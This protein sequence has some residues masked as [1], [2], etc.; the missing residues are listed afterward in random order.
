MLPREVYEGTAA[1]K[2]ALALVAG[3]EPAHELFMLIMRILLVAMRGI[4][5]G[6]PYG[7]IDGG[8]D[9]DFPIVFNA[10][11]YPKTL[12]IVQHL[13]KLGVLKLDAE[14]GTGRL[15]NLVVPDGAGREWVNKVMTEMEATEVVVTPEPVANTFAGNEQIRLMDS[16][17]IPT[18]SSFEF[19]L[20]GFKTTMTLTD[21]GIRID[22]PAGRAPA[23]NDAVVIFNL[24][25]LTSFASK[26]GYR[27]FSSPCPLSEIRQVVNL[28]TRMQGPPYTT[29]SLEELIPRIHDDF[30]SFWDTF[31]PGEETVAA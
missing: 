20:E 14:T 25:M 16:V 7:D 31:Q 29:A 30:K 15:Y 21:A 11:Y 19:W 3:T 9:V 12:A 27:G 10:P 17:G 2:M 18:D 1:G 28:V 13:E 4:R 22:L 24:W 23:E 8:I 5:I 26:H 6:T